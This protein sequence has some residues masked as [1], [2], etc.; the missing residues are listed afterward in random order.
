MNKR[1]ISLLIL[2]GCASVMIIRYG[3]SALFA[4]KRDSSSDVCSSLSNNSKCVSE[5]S[6]IQEED[7]K[8]IERCKKSDKTEDECKKD[9]KKFYDAN[10]KAFEG[11]WSN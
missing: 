2:A 9:C 6:I 4:V 11:K 3:S 7:I 10:L 5:L 1:T 8:C